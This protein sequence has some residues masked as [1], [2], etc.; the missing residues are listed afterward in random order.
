[1]PEGD[2]RLLVSGIGDEQSKVALL[3]KMLFPRPTLRRC[4]LKTSGAPIINS[5]ESEA[6]SVRTLPMVCDFTY[7]RLHT[8]NFFLHS[9]NTN[10][11]HKT[12]F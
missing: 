6:L 9:G 2:E 7:L 1:M 8:D 4:Y 11:S 12:F 10:L 5:E 3:S